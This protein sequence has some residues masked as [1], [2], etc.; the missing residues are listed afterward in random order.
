MPI[1]EHGVEP[2]C[3]VLA[4]IAKT[5]LS[6][7]VIRF[8]VAL[9]IFT[10]LFALATSARIETAVPNLVMWAAAALGFSSIIAF[11]FLI[12]Y[13]AR[14]LRP[15]SIVWRVGEAGHS[16]IKSVSPNMVKST[17]STPERFCIGWPDRQPSWQI[18]NCSGCTSGGAGRRSA[19]RWR[20]DRIRAVRWRFRCRGRTSFLLHGNSG[21]I[22]ERKLRGAVAFGPERTIEQDSTFA[23][24]VI[25]DIAI[26]ALSKAIN[27]L[28]TA[29]LAID[30][31]H[32]LLRMVGTR[33]RHDEQIVDG[34]GL[35]RVVFRTPNWKDFVWLTFREIR[36]YG[37]EN[38]QIARRLRA[39]IDNLVQTLPENR[40]PALR[41]ELDLLDRTI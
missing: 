40:R 24:R 35:L 34:T 21:A 11:L 2:V 19:P 18:G 27:D 4:I 17:V 1:D 5:L 12:D 25:V 38:F 28:T 26:K 7:N 29:V 13:A 22:D 32:R 15:V 36:H 41:Q 8:T 6:N 16:V 39:M 33:H 37:A 20:C 14:L 9:F 30:Q 10:M 3:R 23:F 31:V